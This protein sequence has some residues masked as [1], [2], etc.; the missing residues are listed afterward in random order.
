[1]RRYLAALAILLAAAT[2]HAQGT[3]TA[4]ALSSYEQTSLAAALADNHGTIDPAPDGKT[5][6]EIVVVP[7]EVIEDRD[8]AP[9]FL[10]V[11]HATTKR[12]RI[13]SEV[14]IPIGGTYR[15]YLVDDTVRVL[16]GY[17]QLSLVVAAP[18]KGSA[19]DRVRLLVVTKDTW[20]LRTQFEMKLGSNGLDVLRLEPTERNIAGTMNSAL[21][22]FE[23]YPEN[24]NVGVGLYMPRLTP[25]FYFVVDLNL[26]VNRHTGDPEGTSGGVSLFQPIRSTDQTTAWQVGARWS[27]L[28]VRRY[29]GAKLA[30]FDAKATPD[31]DDIPDQ[32][33]ARTM[34]QSASWNR[35]FGSAH[36]FDLTL[37]GELNVRKSVGLDP[38]R[39]PKE[40]VDEYERARVATSYERVG[41]FVQGRVYESR[42]VRLHDVDVL[43]LG[44]DFRL[45]YDVLAR[46]Y[47]VLVGNEHFVGLDAI[48]QYILPVGNGFAR[49]AGETIYEVGPEHVVTENF[50]AGVMLMSPVLPFGRFVFDSLYLARPI[51]TLNVRSVLGGEGRL[52]GYP[53]A[54]FLGQ[55]LFAYNFELRTKPIEILACQVG[56]ALFHDLGDAFDGKDVHPKSSAGFGLRTVFPQLDKRVWRFDVAF[57]IVR[58]GGEGPVSFYLSFEQAFGS[59]L[60]LPP[61]ASPT[62]GILN[63]LEGALG[64]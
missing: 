50:A 16:R 43:G 55:N 44:E 35:S 59:S 47:P 2:A 61:G 5:L 23:L 34:V 52:R 26:A 41:P 53:S 39:Y 20:S 22:R 36:K 13:E 37:G 30:R 56:G 11:F 60:V 9:S 57:P 25:Q 42:F 38:S 33:R 31:D 12:R 46:V 28:F 21:G 48:A 29:V 14:T 63:P 32:W 3:S 17:Q 58:D 64:Q 27:N 10:N 54:A 15:Q 7:L 19:P 40:V 4:G 18:L 6:E 51:N 1:M 62:P 49:A 45:G 8:P 24:M